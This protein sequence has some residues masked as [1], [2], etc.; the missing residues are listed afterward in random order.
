MT[1]KRAKG[2][3]PKSQPAA[4]AKP[5][6]R[7]M[8]RASVIGPGRGR[9]LSDAEIA[10]RKAED[11]KALRDRPASIGL[12]GPAPGKG[13]R[14]ELL[15][16]DTALHGWSHEGYAATEKAAKEMG[17]SRFAAFGHRWKVRKIEGRDGN[18]GP[19]ANG[20][21]P[22]P[23][24]PRDGARGRRTTSTRTGYNASVPRVT[25]PNQDPDR[26]EEEIGLAERIEEICKARRLARP[27]RLGHMRRQALLDWL[28][29]MDPGRAE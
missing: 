4:G 26:T 21:G 22:G 28:E 8:S 19:G 5:P 7:A 18:R 13:M 29:R 17:R 11:Q 6:K 20:P 12:I 14:Y 3:S 15:W 25:P 9:P 27:A 1:K 24:R 16:W 23:A 2:E 10:R